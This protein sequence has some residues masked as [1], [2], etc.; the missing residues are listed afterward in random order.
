MS[1][2]TTDGYKYSQAGSSVIPGAGGL[3][4]NLFKFFA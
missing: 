4:S 1:Y 3:C 2:F